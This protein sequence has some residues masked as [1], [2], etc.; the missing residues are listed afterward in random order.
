MKIAGTLKSSAIN[1]DGI[2]FVVFVQG[3][4]HYCP[5]CQNPDTWSFEDGEEVDAEELAAQ[6]RCEFAKHPWLDGLTLSGGDPF[7][8]QEE[9]VRLLKLLPGINV[10]I[11]TGFTYE[12]IC[13]TELAGLADVIVDGPYMDD[14]RCEG[15]MYGSSNQKIIRRSQNDRL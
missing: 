10:W 13:D 15:K 4:R 1:G 14:L 3:C 8:Q 7:Y 12:E 2:R 5:G 9:C 11:Y 6:I